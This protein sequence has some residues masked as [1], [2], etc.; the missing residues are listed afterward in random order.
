VRALHV[1]AEA[2]PRFVTEAGVRS[3]VRALGDAAGLTRMGVALRTVPPG[4]ASTH[5]HYHEI[6]EEWAYVLAGS[7]TVRIG[8]DRIGVRPGSF[9][10][11][12]PGPRPH[13]FLA[14]GPEPL[15]FLEGGERR[16]EDTGWWVDLRIGWKDGKRADAV[17]ALPP[18]LGDAGQHLHVEAAE[19]RPFQHDV[20][21]AARR[22]M[23]SLARETGLAHQAVR[24]TRVAAGDRSTAYH[25]HDRTDEWVYVLRGRARAR[26]GEDR[27]EVGEGDFLGHPA[28]GPAHA[29]EPITDLEYLM[30]GMV[31]P[32]DVVLYPEARVQRRGG[33]L[34]PLGG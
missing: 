7:G 1:R 20:D 31:D 3:E 11:F 19:L 18:E 23:R 25:T 14:E 4:F 13:H 15:G 26:V 10:G 27:F 2:R 28:G 30:G 22:V 21:P 17:G 24:W 34:E 16:R 5:R 33:R 12:P 6:E 9:V 32:G 29:M 8:P